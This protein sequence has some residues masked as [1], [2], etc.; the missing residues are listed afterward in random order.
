MDSNFFIR[1][2]VKQADPSDATFAD[3]VNNMAAQQLKADALRDVGSLG[4]AALGIGA[5]G[6][7]AVGL[8]NV[9][10]RNQQKKNRAGPALLPLPFPVEKAGSFTGWLFGDMASTKAGIPLYG[11]AMLGVGLGGAALGWGGMDRLLD[12]RRKA[13]QDVELE[14]ARSQFHQA[15]MSQY[16]K[17]IAALPKKKEEKKA[18]DALME[19]V[20]QDL[21]RL[22]GKCANILNNYQ[23]KQG[24]DFAN[25]GGMAAGGYG[26]YAGLSGLLTGSLV[27][28]AL[29]KRSQQAVLEKAIQK[30]DRRRFAQSPTEI[31]AVPEPV[32]SG[33]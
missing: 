28:N 29:K 13:E 32:E 22:W 9:I 15:L 12:A 4:L 19:K 30:R 17:P 24:L 2:L 5:A 3:A 31:Y 1:G 10:K 14:N 26:V 23:L 7:G 11:P 27:Y 8:Y 18:E 20:G 25:L 6:R 33:E 16:D 21:D